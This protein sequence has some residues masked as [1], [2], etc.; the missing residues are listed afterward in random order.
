MLLLLLLSHRREGTGW[1]RWLI[2]RT[3]L[4]L[5]FIPVA[6]TLPAQSLY[7]IWSLFLRGWFINMGSQIWNVRENTLPGWSSQAN[8]TDLQLQLTTSG[9][10]IILTMCLEGVLRNVN[11][12]LYQEFQI[13]QEGQKKRKIWY[14]RCLWPW[15]SSYIPI[16]AKGYYFFFFSAEK[17]HFWLKLCTEKPPIF[18]QV[19]RPSVRIKWRESIKYSPDM[20]QFDISVTFLKWLIQ[21]W[22][23]WL[24]GKWQRDT[25]EDGFTKE[26]NKKGK[27]YTVSTVCF[28]RKIRLTMTHYGK[29][30]LGYGAK[31]L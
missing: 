10:R 31:R 18:D 30:L 2:H 15:V 21:E 5:F 14:T 20:Y 17:L 27:C 24:T 29:D 23:P 26:S 9:N 22:S 6:A 25:R 11:N 7:K 13:L 12:V 3:T 8:P 19:W 4:F 16:A 1:G 28:I